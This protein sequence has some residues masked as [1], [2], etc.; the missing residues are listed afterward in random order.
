MVKLMANT[1][2]PTNIF[3]IILLLSAALGHSQAKL[4]A[5]L[6]P[7]SE[8]AFVYY[9]LLM[10]FELILSGFL[11]FP[12]DAPIYF[13]WTMDI[14]FTRWAIYGLLYNQ[15][16]NFKENGDLLNGILN[17]QGEIVLN[18][19]GL[20]SFDIFRSIWILGIYFIGLEILVII[21]MLPKRDKLIK[22]ISLSNSNILWDIEEQHH[23]QQQG[24]GQISGTSQSLQ[25]DLISNSINETHSSKSLFE[26]F[27]IPTIVSQVTPSLIEPYGKRM[28]SFSQ[29]DS[30]F[31][32]P[33]GRLAPR[34]THTEPR[35]SWRVSTALELHL[36]A[37]LIFRKVSYII[38]NKKGEDIK[39]LQEISGVVKSGE[40]CAIMGSSGAGM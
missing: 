18:F 37:N 10:S 24:Q 17:N 40:L 30:Q 4:C 38:K 34:L 19:Y 8:T 36:R 6:S 12:D 14:M 16:N 27:S 2:G 35:D 28:T 32:T 39:L 20:S 13:K 31:L 9:A 29:M 5:F 15:F 3:F 26:R 22:V 33:E 11:I 7:N 21:S 1:Y 23:H 25:I